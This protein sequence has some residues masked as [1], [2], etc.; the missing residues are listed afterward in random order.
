MA[1]NAERHRA[2]CAAVLVRCQALREQKAKLALLRARGA[3]EEAELYR[4]GAARMAAQATRLRADVLRAHYHALAQDAVDAAGFRALRHTEE[5]L[6]GDCK[7]SAEKLE[8]AEAHACKAD[9]ALR[10]AS[11]VFAD[12]VQRSR[13]RNGVAEAAQGSLAAALARTEA[14]DRAATGRACR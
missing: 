6:V 12:E 1:G 4:R 2:R 11:R 5:R 9:A 8:Q 14:G 13:K 7:R 3:C 10:D